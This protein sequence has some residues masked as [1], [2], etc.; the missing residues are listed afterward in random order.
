MLDQIKTFFAA[1]AHPDGQVDTAD[2]EHRLQLAVGALL[3]EMARMDG[4]TEA[5]EIV[6]VEHAVRD[7]LGLSTQEVAEL[8][9]LAEAQRSKATDY[10]QFTSLINSEYSVDEKVAL[11]ERLWRVAYADRTLCRY[12]EHLVRKLAD[13]LYVPH[14]RFVAA[15]QRAADAVEQAQ[16]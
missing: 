9:R 11:I 13:L 4:D 15:R 14:S 7:E 8:L 10:F 12:E 16:A 6:A 1:F 5:D 3:L 2:R